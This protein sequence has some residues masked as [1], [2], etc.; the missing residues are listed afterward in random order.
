MF[1]HH[2]KSKVKFCENAIAVATI[3]VSVSGCQWHQSPQCT[4]QNNRLI[5]LLQRLEETLEP[6]YAVSAG[7]MF[8]SSYYESISS[9]PP[10]LL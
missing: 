7:N 4:G 1:A 6:T 8:I 2:T 3:T 10:P 5:H 9:L